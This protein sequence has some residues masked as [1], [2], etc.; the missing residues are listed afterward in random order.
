MNCLVP[1]FLKLVRTYRKLLGLLQKCRKT[2]DLRA[3][4]IPFVLV[5]GIPFALTK[6]I[7]KPAVKRI[8]KTSDGTHILQQPTLRKCQRQKTQNSNKSRK[9]EESFG[10]LDNANFGCKHFRN[11]SGLQIEF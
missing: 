11:S 2:T 4:F 5:P 8:R 7:K 10:F 1:S 3:P 9:F 6:E